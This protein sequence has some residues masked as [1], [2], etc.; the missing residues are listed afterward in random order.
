MIVLIGFMGAGKSTVGRLL[1]TRLGLDFIDSDAVIE[2]EQ[3]LSI[4]DIFEGYGESGFRRIEAETI[5]RLLSGPEAVLSLGGG[6][7]GS[8]DVQAALAGHQVVL[9]DVELA[10]ALRRVGEDGSRPMLARSDVAELYASR[11]RD[12]RDAA[13]VI[14]PVTGRT[15]PEIVAAVVTGLAAPAESD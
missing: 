7:V 9:L 15:P 8:T 11:Q 5:A 2:V 4:P 12:Y 3:G 6:A 13:T 14:V 1:A 10:E